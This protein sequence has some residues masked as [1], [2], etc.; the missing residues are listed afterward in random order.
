MF[1][2]GCFTWPPLEPIALCGHAAIPCG[3]HAAGEAEIPAQEPIV[4]GRFHGQAVLQ[5]RVLA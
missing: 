1:Q 3:E 5:R 4:V 2:F